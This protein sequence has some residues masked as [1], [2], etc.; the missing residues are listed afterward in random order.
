[1]FVPF[2]LCKRLRGSG[3]NVKG[4][5]ASGCLRAGESAC[6]CIRLFS[7]PLFICCPESKGFLPTL[8]N[9]VIIGV[10]RACMFVLLSVDSGVGQM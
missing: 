9:S 10:T 1:M 2:W 7:D 4:I 8:T 6:H 3:P 5:I